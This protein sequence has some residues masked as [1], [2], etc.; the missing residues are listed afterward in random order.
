M[1]TLHF[2]RL[3]HSFFVFEYSS[4]PLKTKILILEHRMANISTDWKEIEYNRW[5]VYPADMK[6]NSIHYIMHIHTLRKKKNKNRFDFSWHCCCVV[7]T[8]H[9]FFANFSCTHF[10]SWKLCSGI[11]CLRFLI[12][13]LKNTNTDEH[14]LF[15]WNIVM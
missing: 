10:Q 5:K 11:V 3:F 2:N 12:W 14:F 13:L 15:Q 4:W 8:V 7:V 6:T 1:Q 9:G